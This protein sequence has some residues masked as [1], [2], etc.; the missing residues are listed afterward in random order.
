MATAACPPAAPP[1]VPLPPTPEERELARSPGS[2]PEQIA[3]REKVVR[4]FYHNKEGLGDERCAQDLKG[5]DLTKPVEV[6]D[7]P[8]PETMKQYV[9][10]G[11]A[12]PGNFFDPIGGQSADSLGLN[13]DPAIRESKTFK[14]PPGQGLKSTAAPITDDWTDRN[15]PVHTKG[16]GTQIVVDGPTRDMFAGA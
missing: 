8:P 3:A 4:D 10:K 13:G 2:S 7:F 9:R 11:A 1:P 12:K 6:V 14:T 16:G 15:N 5:M